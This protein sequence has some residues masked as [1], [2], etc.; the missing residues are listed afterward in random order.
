MEWGAGILIAIFATVGSSIFGGVETGLTSAREIVLLH[1]ARNGAWWSGFAARLMQ[2]REEA[3]IGAVVG[4]NIT[5]VIGSAAA[6]AAFMS[7]FGDRGEMYAAAV[8]SAVTVIFGEA[9]P[10]AAFRARPETLLW[11]AGPPYRV[12]ELLLTPVIWLA[13]TLSRGILAVLRVAPAAQ[14]TG[15]SRQAIQLVLKK[16]LQEDGGARSQQRLLDRCLSSLTQPVSSRITPL[17]KAACL[18]PDATVRDAVALVHGSGH[19]RLPLRDERGGLRG[20]ILFRDLL[21]APEEAAAVDLERE[22][23]FLAADIGMDEAIASLL[24]RRATLAA[25]RDR[26]GKTLGIITLEDLLEPLVGE[27]NDEHDK[28]AAAR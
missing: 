23:P 5:V 28:P 11:L 16:S 2:R 9:L 26:R 19:S 14:I 8:M 15:L 4:N 20:L 10:K 6:T 25:V 3:I 12:I 21:D 27:I 17:D 7:R 22:I 18:D 24:R 13:V 1:R